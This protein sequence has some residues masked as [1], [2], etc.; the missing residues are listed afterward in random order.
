M[1]LIVRTWQHP[2]SIWWGGAGDVA[3]GPTCTA[4]PPQ[5]RVIQSKTSVVTSENPCCSG[6]HKTSNDRNCDPPESPATLLCTPSQQWYW[7]ILSHCPQPVAACGRNTKASSLLGEKNALWATQH[8]AR[9][10]LHSTAAKTL[11][12][13][14][15]L[16]S[17]SARLRLASGWRS[18]GLSQVP[19][20]L[21]LKFFPNKILAHLFLF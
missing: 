14:S 16:P 1:F 11:P 21:S 20:Q 5:Q 12:P 7:T 10:R 9:P 13:T 8:P 17:S 18:L 15:F 4:Q 19:Y 6:N 2:T 3:K